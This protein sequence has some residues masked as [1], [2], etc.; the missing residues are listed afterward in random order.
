MIQEIHAVNINL[1]E[2]IERL[3][4]DIETIIPI[5]YPADGRKVAMAEFLKAVGKGN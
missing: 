1:L 3:K 2:N 5:H 4:L